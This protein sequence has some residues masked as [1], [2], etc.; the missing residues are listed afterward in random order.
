MEGFHIRVRIYPQACGDFMEHTFVV[1]THVCSFSSRDWG[2][3][4]GGE[5]LQSFVRPVSANFRK[6]LRAS[7]FLVF[8][9]CL[10]AVG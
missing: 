3:L 9:F 2:V 4:K 8:L 7:C 6:F 5:L 1:C 10:I